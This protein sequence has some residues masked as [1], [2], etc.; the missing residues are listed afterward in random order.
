VVLP[1][2]RPG[3]SRDNLLQGL[4]DRHNEL[5]SLSGGGPGQAQ[6]RIRSYLEWVTNAVRHLTYQV[7]AADIERLVLTPG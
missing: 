3:V 2:P 5:V 1:S 4:R 7:S 6:D